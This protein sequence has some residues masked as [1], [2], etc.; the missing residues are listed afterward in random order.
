MGWVL[1]VVGGIIAVIP[2]MYQVVNGAT[3]LGLVLLGVG[4]TILLREERAG[5]E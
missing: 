4:T 5:A 2:G 3:L 1:M